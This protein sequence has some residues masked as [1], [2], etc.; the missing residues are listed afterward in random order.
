MDINDKL[1]LDN[2]DLLGKVTNKDQLLEVHN[3]YAH[4]ATDIAAFIRSKG[5][6]SLPIVNNYDLFQPLLPLHLLTANH[7]ALRLPPGGIDNGYYVKSR[8]WRS[9]YDDIGCDY[10]SILDFGHEDTVRKF[11]NYAKP[12]LQHGILSLIPS[13]SITDIKGCGAPERVDFDELLKAPDE[14][15]TAKNSGDLK[16]GTA[17]VHEIVMPI[18]FGARNSDFLKLVTD[19]WV[20]FQRCRERLIYASV[21]MGHTTSSLEHDLLF[22]KIKREIIDDGVSGLEDEFKRLDRKGIIKATGGILGSASLFIV[23]IT[24]SSTLGLL[25]S[26]VAAAIL[27][28]TNCLNYM[29]YKEGLNGI[30]SNPFYFLW[31]L[32]KNE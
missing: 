28:T 13:N 18:I 4:Q 32:A 26:A 7:T 3:F 10:E 2:I 8:R 30:K 17:L 23:N 12:L 16:I 19:E 31:K 1:L 22:K 29:E 24:C 15:N 14:A 11:I 25:S 20:S 9:S 27:G 6:V 5:L 21:Q